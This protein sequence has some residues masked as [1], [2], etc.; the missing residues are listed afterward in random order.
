MSTPAASETL[1][2]LR[3]PSAP[4]Q[5]LSDGTMRVVQLNREKALNALNREMIDLIRAAFDE[6]IPSPN[7][8][9]V[10]LRGVGR[11]LSA[12]GD[13]LSVV[14][15]A[16]SGDAAQRAEAVEF[17]RKELIEDY[18]VHAMRSLSSDAGHPKTFIGLWDGITM[19]G[20]VGLT[21][22]AP[23]RIASERTLFSMPETSIGYFPD[24]GLLHTFTRLDGGIGMYLALTSER[25]SGADVYLAG[26]ATHYVRSSAVNDLVQRLSA[27]PLASA[28]KEETINAVINEYASDPFAEDPELAATS[29]FLGAV[30]VAIDVV[31]TRSSVENIVG[32]LDD[33]A[34]R[35]SDAFVVQELGKRGVEL[36]DTIVAWAAKT[37]DTLLVRSPRSLKVTFRGMQLAKSQTLPET[38][39]M[40][41]RIATAFCDP[42]IGRDFITGVT[43]VLGRDPATGKRREGTP[44]WEPSRLEDV[45]DE[46][47]QTFFFGDYELAKRKGLSTP[48]P[49]L[50]N[51]PSDEHRG[52]RRQRNKERRG[53]GPMNW[54]PKYNKYA[55]PS[56]A[57]LEALREGSHPAAGSFVLEPQ[58]LLDTI[59]HYKDHKPA[60]RV[61]V[62]D[63]LDRR[64]RAS[65]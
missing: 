11:A 12:G 51:V 27:L 37:K 36:S 29:R 52:S 30:R 32:A 62:Q 48:L 35:R 41:M 23:I 34:Q 58:E 47:V 22:H 5:L 33:L 14:K 61:K 54:D 17:F 20:G 3:S 26:L 9:T 38:M 4:V 65:S 57:E 63:W 59:S 31:F 55:L 39:H 6:V 53:L 2:K 16:D 24:V 40:S 46:D 49:T 44:A 13:V 50:D 19:G 43:H 42:S 28:A 10:L 64:A 8:A 45:R 1:A 25:L 56:E 60:L 21:V 18:R 7:A 15:M